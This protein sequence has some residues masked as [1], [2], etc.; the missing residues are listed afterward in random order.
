MAYS[1]RLGHA[2]PS[3]RP[4]LSCSWVEGIL[5]THNVAMKSLSNTGEHVGEIFHYHL[6][7]VHELWPGRVRG[8]PMQI[9]MGRVYTLLFTHPTKLL[10]NEQ[11]LLYV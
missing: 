10:H 3:C 7:H 11:P 4:L 2:R 9:A 8:R 1:K 5:K 6:V